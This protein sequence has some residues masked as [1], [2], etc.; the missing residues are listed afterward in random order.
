MINFG[1]VTG[2]ANAHLSLA[3]KLSEAARNNVADPSH[4]MSAEVSHGRGGAGNINPDSTQYIDGEV[5]RSG[6]EG[7]HGDGAYSSGRGGA[8]NIADVGT[9]A[10]QRKDQDVIPDVAVRASHDT[11]DYHTGR[12]GAGNEHSAAEREKPPPAKSSAHGDAPISL[13][14]KLKEKLFGAFKK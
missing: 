5:V 3:G 9:A 4:L 1:Y 12:G 13:A 14:D 2:A 8:G 6:I 11:Q 7:S 10:S